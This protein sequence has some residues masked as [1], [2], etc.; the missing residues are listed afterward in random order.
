MSTYAFAIGPA[1][2][3]DTPKLPHLQSRLEKD[4][5]GLIKSVE[6][7]AFPFTKFVVIRTADGVSQVT[8][9]EYPSSTPLYVDSRLL[10]MVAEEP[11][12]R[13]RVLP[14]VPAILRFLQSVVGVRYFWGGNWAKGISSMSDLYPQLTAPEDQE[15][16][17][18]K[19]VDCSGLLYQATN[20]CTPRNTGQLCTYGQ[21]IKVD[22]DSVEAV[23]K[24][25]K[26]L[27]I[28]VWR[29][30]VLCVLDPDHFIES[31]V[32]QGVIVSGFTDRYKHFHGRLR[33]EQ[34]PFSLRRWHPQLL[35]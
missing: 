19:G 27:D 31:V 2:L 34:K 5:Q 22:Q 9:N 26:P 20:G 15:D 13:T 1:P 29:G 35:A 16:R 18:C 28:M 17:I 32:G 25:V 4:S 30:H 12:E 21:E 7:I 14:S 10:E 3:Y 11:P 24:I 8:T 33:A 23:Q 6:V